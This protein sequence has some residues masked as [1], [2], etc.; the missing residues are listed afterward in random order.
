MD[1]FDVENVVDCLET[2]DE[3]YGDRETTSPIC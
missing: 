2:F 1:M 3:R